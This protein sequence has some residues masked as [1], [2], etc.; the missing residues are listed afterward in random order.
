MSTRQRQAPFTLEVLTE[1]LS[2]SL[3][4]PPPQLSHQQ[5]YQIIKFEMGQHHCFIKAG[6]GQNF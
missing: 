1:F 6:S 4:N 2:V 3:S 5:K